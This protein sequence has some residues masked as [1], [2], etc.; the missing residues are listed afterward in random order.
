MTGKYLTRTIKTTLV[1][2]FVF[3]LL[4]TV[5]RQV[6]D[7]L[8][9]MWAPIIGNFFQIIAVILGLFGA[10]QRYRS[11]VLVY[12]VWSLLWLGW[13]IFVICL[14]LE[15]GILNRNRG[16]YI[17]T[18]GT[19]SKSWWLEHGI[20]CNIT[21]TS[22]LG[23]SSS[24]S[25]KPPDAGRPIPPEEFV[26]GCVLQYY[27]VEVIHAAVQVL[28]GMAGLGVALVIIQASLDEDDTCKYLVTTTT[29]TRPLH[30]LPAPTPPNPAPPSTA[31]SS[32]LLVG[33]VEGVRRKGGGGY[34]A[35]AQRDSWSL[36]TYVSYHQSMEWFDS[37]V[38][39]SHLH[40]HPHPHAT[41]RPVSTASSS[42]QVTGLSGMEEPGRSS[43]TGFE[44][45]GSLSSATTQPYHRLSTPGSD[46]VTLVQT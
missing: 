12:A 11:F 23:A 17:L 4:S 32:S 18:M 7:F 22:W 26:E 14:Y 46:Q 36:P 3:Q 6:F 24:S 31:S 35:V 21:N 10:C 8:G 27:Y 45:N 37:P 15:V 5:E 19:D 16:R 25:S 34:V 2:V 43:M 1:A 38:T 40:P 33:R 20:G 42:A 13:N 39:D 28:L 29:Y 30:T 41:H 9:Y 44:S